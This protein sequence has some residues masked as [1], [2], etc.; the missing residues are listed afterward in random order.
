MKKGTI[1]QTSL[2]P[3]PAWFFF[4]DFLVSLGLDTSKHLGLWE[5]SHGPPDMEAVKREVTFDPSYSQLI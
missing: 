5:E 4:L 3:G 2:A 1:Q